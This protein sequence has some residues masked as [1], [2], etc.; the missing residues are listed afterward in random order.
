[1]PAVQV[2]AGVVVL[3]QARQVGRLQALGVRG[4]GGIFGGGSGGVQVLVHLGQARLSGPHGDG[5]GEGVAHFHDRAGVVGTVRRAQGRMLVARGKLRSGGQLVIGQE[6]A[7]AR[8]DD[9]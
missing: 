3:A 8:I 9:D 5:N 6:A 4:A 2:V 1:M 7:L